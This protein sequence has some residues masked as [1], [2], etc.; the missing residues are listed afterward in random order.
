LGSASART[1]TLRLVYAALGVLLAVYLVL[2]CTSSSSPALDGWG[3]GAFELLASGLCLAAGLH[4]RTARSVPLLLGASLLAWTLGHIAYTVESLGGATP[5]SPSVAD[6]LYLSFFPLA[7]V[8]LVLYLRGEVRRLATPSWLDGLVAGLGAAAVCAAFAF[9]E[10]EYL[11]GGSVLSTAVNLA[12][13]IG[14]LLLLLLVVGGLTVLAGRSRGPWLVIAGGIALAVVGDTFNLFQSSSWSSHLGVV[15]NGIAWPGAIL[16]MSL[17]MWLPRVR[18]DPRASLRPTGFLLPGLAAVCGLAILLLGT[19]ESVNR[20][21]VGL[22]AATLS[23]VGVRMA[24]SVRALRALTQERQRLSVTDH[25][26]GLGNRRHLFDVLEAFFAEE[27]VADTPR[28]LALLY[29]DL[30]RFKRVND[31]FGHPAGDELLRQL[32]ARLAHSLEPTDLVARIGGDEFGVV[33]TDADAAHA[34]RV[35]QRLAASLERPFALE[36]V[37]A[38][39]AANIGIA[40][41]PA[42]AGD[43]A[44]LIS[45]ADA[46]MYRAKLGAAPCAR[47]EASYDEAG[48]RLRLAE[49]LRAALEHGALVLH[50]QPQL[51]L[52]SGTCAAV[53]AL[54]RWPHPTL[55]TIP[56]ARF[57]PLA[58]EA[59]LMGALTRLV[60]DRALAQCAAWRTAGREVRVAV[61]VS[62][63]DLLGEGFAEL[64]AGAL[65]RHGLEPACLVVEITETTAI[66]EFDRACAVVQRLRAHG[67]CVSID[68]FGAGFTSLGH[69]SSLAVGELKLDRSFISRLATGEGHQD[70]ELVRAITA[71]GHALRL[72]VVAEGIEDGA[73]LELVRELGCDIGQGFFIGMP[74]AAAELEWGAAA[75]ELAL[76]AETAAEGLTPAPAAARAPAAPVAPRRGGHR[77]RHVSVS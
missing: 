48:S 28:S 39:L 11:T 21:A 34:T 31:T 62:A 12:Y 32:A 14:D 71:L 41:A 15:L 45:C 55:G 35:A 33:L 24:L 77:A 46:A 26:T 73:T 75:E 37:R 2:L 69:L 18:S 68:D 42:D 64:V 61:N 1:Q 36:A 47:Y 74:V 6:A 49:E 3:V 30:E 65:H 22:A 60:L 8:A 67:V 20:I 10:I 16:A 63:S 59:G 27:A 72:R 19:F 54:V 50:Y 29:V 76:G 44:G 9:H 7:Y 40:L 23:V 25:L 57:L 66:T 51:D 58:E 43:P 38:R 4:R 52:R 5:P 53:E 70:R 13:P 17:A 56:P